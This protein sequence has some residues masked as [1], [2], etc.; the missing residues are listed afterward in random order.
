M[1]DLAFLQ[2]QAVLMIDEADAASTKEVDVTSTSSAEA[3][4]AS[5]VGADARVL[6]CVSNDG[7]NIALGVTSMGAAD[8][9]SFR[10]VSGVASYLRVGALTHFRAI[11]DGATKKIWMSK[12][13]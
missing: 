9:D 4:I 1:G 3:T 13:Y 7:A 5:V 10:L 8:A 2:R 6:R 11:S 12:A